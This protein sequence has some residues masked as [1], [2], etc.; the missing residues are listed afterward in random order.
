MH[1]ILALVEPLSVAWHAVKT[2]PFK[3]ADSVL[4]L[5]G[6][7][8]GLAVVQTLVAKGAER[9][10]VSEVASRRR[11]LAKEFG[12]HHVLDPTKDDIV[13]RVREISGDGSGVNVAFDAAGVQAGL[14][15]AIQA[16]RA[17]G[18]LV[19][20][21]VWEKRATIT[22]NWLVFRERRY[23]GVATYQDGDFQD[24]IDAIAA[25]MPIRSSFRLASVKMFLSF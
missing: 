1:E 16:V 20:I 12:A 8:I 14:D 10:I 6:G 18:T 7:P 19:N 17:R 25:G 22:P 4:V 13:S 23:M 15:Q 2:S 24:V 21:A 11:E 5:G 3:K 9:I